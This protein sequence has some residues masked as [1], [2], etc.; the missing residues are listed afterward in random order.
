MIFSQYLVSEKKYKM[1]T[2]PRKDF[3]ANEEKI[4]SLIKIF[5]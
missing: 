2:F 3:R 1:E 5:P 4:D